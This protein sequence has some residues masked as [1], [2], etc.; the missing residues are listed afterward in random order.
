V[1]CSPVQGD[2]YS[3]LLRTPVRFDAVETLRLCELVY[4]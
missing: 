1:E 4:H 2:Y 3:A